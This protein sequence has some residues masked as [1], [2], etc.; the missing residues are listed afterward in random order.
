LN[1][2]TLFAVAFPIAVLGAWLAQLNWR[3]SSGTHVRLAVRGFDP[4]DVLAGHYLTYT[5]D[6]GPAGDCPREGATDVPK[7]CMC[8][9]Q[10]PTTQ[11]HEATWAGPCD[12]R[13]LECPLYLEGECRYER[14]TADIERFYFP[15][16]FRSELAIVPEKST[17]DVVVQSNGQALVTGFAVDGVDLLDYAKSRAE[18]P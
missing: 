11:L 17:I 14:F 9:S 18:A 5:V 4:R 12:V 3:E 10:N 1:K 8:L 7:T 13:P 15:E 6:Y 2:T 16:T